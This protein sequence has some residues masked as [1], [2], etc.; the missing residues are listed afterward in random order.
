MNVNAQT[1]L[2]SNDISVGGALG[3]ITAKGAQ[4]RSDADLANAALKGATVGA[5]SSFIAGEEKDKY[6][7]KYADWKAQQV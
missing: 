4:D 7:S 5:L 1:Q 2:A 6:K 3:Q